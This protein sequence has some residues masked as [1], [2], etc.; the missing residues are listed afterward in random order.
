M[1][2]SDEP[3]A[4]QLTESPNP[5]PPTPSTHVD[6]V[7]CFRARR[8][9]PPRPDGPPDKE[10]PLPP[11][12]TDDL[13][14]AMVSALPAP[15]DETPQQM[16][17]RIAAAVVALRSLDA[18]EPI[19]AMLATHVILASQAAHACYRHAGKPNQTPAL[20]SRYFGNATNLTRTA[21]GVLRALEQRQDRAM[22]LANRNPAQWQR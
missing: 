21:I 3:T 19:E 12:F 1:P 6:S 8:P 15:D 13:L 18:Q 14:H 9:G 22:W 7:S 2:P 11:L 4:T 10:D 5:Q 20:A 17:L 16:G